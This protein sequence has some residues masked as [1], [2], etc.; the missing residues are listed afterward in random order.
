MYPWMKGFVC[1]TSRHI[2]LF[3]KFSVVIRTSPDSETDRVINY[4]KSDTGE[5]DLVRGAR[6]HVVSGLDGNF[7]LE[8]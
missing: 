1:K 2:F 5:L 6:D 3:K 7:I 8:H 4:V